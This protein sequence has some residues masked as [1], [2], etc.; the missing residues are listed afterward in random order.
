MSIRLK[1]TM[2]L[3]MLF[4]AAI[5]NVLFIY[6]L[7]KNGERTTYWGVHTH[8]VITQVGDFMTAMVDAET[9][10]RGY[11][12]TNDAEYLEP[13]YTGVSNAKN[14]FDD[15]VRKTADEPDQ[16]QRLK[17]VGSLMEKK[18]DELAHTI[19]VA[20]NKSDESISKAIEIVKND[21]GKRLMDAIRFEML[22]FKNTEL[23]I[24]EQR[25]GEFRENR[26]FINALIIFELMFFVFM[27]V[28]TGL[29]IKN[30]LYQPLKVLIEGTAKM[31]KGEKQQV[32]DLL[33]NDEMGYLLSRFYRMSETVHT[34]TEVLSYEASHDSLT[35]LKNRAGLK[36]DLEE[37]VAELSDDE[38]IAVLFA[39]LNKFKQ[40]NDTLGHD[41]GDAIL[42]ETA[43][44]L[45]N[46][47]R[48]Y[49]AVYRLGG[50]E[51]VV[52]IKGITEVSQAKL[53]VE[54]MIKKFD[55]PFAFQGHTINISISLGVAISPDHSTDSDRL[56][57]LSDAAMYEA[58]RDESV[59]YKLFDDSMIKAVERLSE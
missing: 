39:D 5:G 30:K 1:L 16:Q 7:D 12:I 20:Q 45:N 51:F 40:L 37:A 28:V 15:L 50:D 13:Y 22:A 36:R 6:I 24:L 32:S 52:V 44:R 56:L 49:D 42:A 43:I 25:K 53:V 59:A 55:E 26:A 31:E 14:H 46:S 48:L 19:N 4:I 35:G 2:L 21:A 47:V 33:P 11:L 27:S 58:K 10:Q 9:G 17:N 38:K 34:K 8:K 57:S 18:F 29:F 23:L 54:K 3:S 41:V